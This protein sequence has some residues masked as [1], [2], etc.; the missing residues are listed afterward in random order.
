MQWVNNPDARNMKKEHYDIIPDTND[1]LCNEKHGRLNEM[2]YKS[3]NRTLQES[4]R[5]NTSGQP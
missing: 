3:Y 5:Q 4:I 1:A 2:V